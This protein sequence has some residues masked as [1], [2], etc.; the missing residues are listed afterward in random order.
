MQKIEP[1][2]PDPDVPLLCLNC[3]ANGDLKKCLLLQC[4]Y[5]NTFVMRILQVKLRKISLM[6][7]DQ[8]WIN[9]NDV[10]DPNNDKCYHGWN[11]ADYMKIV[12]MGFLKSYHMI[13]RTAMIDDKQCIQDTDF[14]LPNHIDDCYFCPAKGNLQDCLVTKCNFKRNFA[15]KQL[16]TKLRKVLLSTENQTWLENF[17]DPY[18]V[19]HHGACYEGP[20]ED[21][22]E[23]C[24]I[25]ECDPIETHTKYLDACNHSWVDA[26]F[27]IDKDGYTPAIQLSG[28]Y[29]QKCDKR[30]AGNFTDVDW[31][32]DLPDY[33]DLLT[34]EEFVE[35]CRDGGFINYDGSG[36]YCN[37]DNGEAQNISAR[38]GN[39]TR[40]RI[41][42]RFTHVM[43]YNR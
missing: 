25:D 13:I 16:S 12:V 43:W 26:R 6:K 21:I 5:Y 11:D 39:I 8:L 34:L 10:R 42:Y 1:L 9:T 29:C 36:Y 40:D 17:T 22:Y 14:A 38:P 24:N 35:T 3:Q 18:T 19:Q 33:G 4:K 28:E 27:P 32:H 7:K 20:L 23:Y 15:F 41:D 30:R 37:G 2:V 31:S